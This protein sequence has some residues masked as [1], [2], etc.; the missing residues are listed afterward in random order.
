MEKL[1]TT[2]YKTAEDYCEIK[3]SKNLDTIQLD[4]EDINERIEKTKKECQDRKVVL[5]NTKFGY[6]VKGT[7][8]QAQKQ[9][10]F[11]LT[12][13]PSLDATIKKRFELES[14]PKDSKE[15]TKS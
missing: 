15:I 6:L 12:S 7:L 1:P 8:P 9:P 13:E 14:L 4:I 3:T 5:H 10:I 11:C 2:L